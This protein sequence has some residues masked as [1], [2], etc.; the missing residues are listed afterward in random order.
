MIGGTHQGAPPIYR[1]SYRRGWKGTMKDYKKYMIRRDP[2]HGWG[3]WFLVAMDPWGPRY[4]R[5]TS[6]L[7]SQA[8][9]MMMVEYRERLY[10]NGININ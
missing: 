10:A 8:S 2:T 1:P 5:I 4:L 7:P 6:W 9:A 3:L